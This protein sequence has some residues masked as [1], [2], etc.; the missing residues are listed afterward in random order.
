MYM[1]KY[2]IVKHPIENIYLHERFVEAV[3]KYAEPCRQYIGHFD[4]IQY[5]R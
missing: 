5:I 3:L 4:I 2:T 1:H